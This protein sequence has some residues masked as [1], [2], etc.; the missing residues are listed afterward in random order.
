MVVG[1]VVLFGG[2]AYAGE[3][4]ADKVA[5]DSV[6]SGPS[7]PNGVTDMVIGSINLDFKSVAFKGEKFRM[8]QLV[9]QPGGVVPWHN[10]GERPAIIYVVKGSITEYRSTCAVPIEHK[11]GEVTSEYGADLSHWWKNN[12]SEPAVLLSSDILHD[13]STDKS[14]M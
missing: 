14:S 9:V 8:R 3:C 5:K 10:H 4:P 1:A 6:T 2:N 13:T 11:S 7:T 12:S